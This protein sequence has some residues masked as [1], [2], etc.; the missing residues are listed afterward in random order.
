MNE[1][2]DGN[3]RS[4]T[5]K[6]MISIH[7]HRLPGGN[8]EPDYRHIYFSPHLDDAVLSCGGRI[9]RQTSA[10]LPILVVTVFAG[11]GRGAT[12]APRALAP[13]QDIAA[14]RREDRRALA[15]VAADHVWLDFPDAIQRHRRYASLLGITAPDRAAGGAAGCR[16][17]G[18][19]GAHRPA[20]AR[21]QAVL[22]VGDRQPRRPSNRIGGRIRLAAHPTPGPD[23]TSHSTKIPPTCAYPTCCGSGSSR[24][25]SQRRPARRPR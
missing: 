25:A 16:G 6:T 23:T 17:G 1:R 7:R 4:V 3:G 12:R 14:R 8:F 15:V 9:A 5:R 24:S 13:F 19:S 22:P 18:R 21:R 10:G 2:G 20:L 11:S